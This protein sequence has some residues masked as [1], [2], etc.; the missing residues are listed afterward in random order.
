M[1]DLLAWMVFGLIAGA[2]A[3]WFMPGDDPGGCIITM[4]I[5]LAGAVAGGFIARN[6]LGLGGVG[7]RDFGS[8]IIAILGAIL[9]L[10][11]YRM[12]KR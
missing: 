9:L 4:L 7:E 8:L 5:G 3:K 6:V 12:V 2:L 11:I 1:Y 10:G